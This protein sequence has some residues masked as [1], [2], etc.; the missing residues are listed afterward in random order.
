MIK[1]AVLLTVYNRREI[2]L[3]GL[4]SLYQA[5]ET[6]GGDYTFDVYMTDDGS[7]DGTAEAVIKEF[8][9]VVVVQGNGDLFWNRGMIKAWEA[10]IESKLDY[11]FYLWYNDDTMLYQSSLSILFKT[12][13]DCKSSSVIV[14]AIRAN[15][16]NIVSYGGY[17]NHIRKSPNGTAIAIDYMNGNVVL[18]PKGIVEKV[19]VLDPFFRHSY[20]DWEYGYRIRKNNYALFLSPSYVGTCD[21]HDNQEKCYNRNVPLKDRLLYLVSPVGH[22]PKEVFHYGMK[23]EGF[24]YA[25]KYTFAV[26][27]K[28]FFPNL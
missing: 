20:G 25:V 24:F 8:P 26:I 12:Y 11:D 5:I 19:G 18:L 7:T 27:F 14:G 13:F 4:R 1:T 3:Q 9:D 23:T 6:L 17:V 15:T 2:T 22:H 21:R 10:A 16:D 28:A